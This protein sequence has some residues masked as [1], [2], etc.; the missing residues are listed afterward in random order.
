MK[1]IKRLFCNHEYRFSRNI[2]GDEINF[3]SLKH[4]YRSI[5]KCNKCDKLKLEKYLHYEEGEL[6]EE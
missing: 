3:I 5:W 4:V 1:W 2:H 6:N